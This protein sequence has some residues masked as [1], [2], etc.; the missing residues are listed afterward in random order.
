MSSLKLLASVALL[1]ERNS[2]SVSSNTTDGNKNNKKNNLITGKCL[3]E[4]EIKHEF[5][6][7]KAVLFDPTSGEESLHICQTSHENG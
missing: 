2:S 5:K 7:L 1:Q 3:V 4:C 6:S